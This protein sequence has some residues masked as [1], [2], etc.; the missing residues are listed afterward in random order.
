MNIKNNSSSA[1]PSLGSSK[2][3]PRINKSQDSPVFHDS[4][5]EED[6]SDEN[7]RIIC[8]PLKN[9]IRKDIVLKP[10]VPL[11]TIKLL[12]FQQKIMGEV[13]FILGFD[14]KVLY[15]QNFYFM[16][17]NIC[18]VPEQQK[19]IKTMIELHKKVPLE[20]I[21]DNEIKICV[22]PASRIIKSNK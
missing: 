14:Q 7:P 20:W 6:E 19:S 8:I 3:I 1:P 5:E 17:F 12:K 13:Q 21:S 10:A 2:Y 15:D 18:L 4:D 9:K 11:T 22:H 16:K